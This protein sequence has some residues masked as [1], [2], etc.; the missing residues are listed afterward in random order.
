MLGTTISKRNQARLD[1]R[2]GCAKGLTLVHGWTEEKQ[3]HVEESIQRESITIL[4]SSGGAVFCWV[5]LFSS[6]ETDVQQ[7]E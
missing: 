2:I 6:G 1:A 7:I 4:G 5:F 3:N